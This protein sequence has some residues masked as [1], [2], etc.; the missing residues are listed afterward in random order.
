MFMHQIEVFQIAGDENKTK[1]NKKQ[2]S[3]GNQSNA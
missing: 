2:N 3:K 1:Q